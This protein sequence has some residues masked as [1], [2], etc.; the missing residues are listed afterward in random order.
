MPTK[1]FLHEIGV[2][3]DNVCP[4]CES[5]VETIQHLF[6]YCRYIWNACFFIEGLIRKYSGDKYFFL[7][8][9]NRILGHHM[10]PVE[11]LLIVK[12]LKEIWNVRCKLAFNS[13][14]SRSD[15]DIIYQY[16]INLKN[17]LVMEKNRLR[18]DVFQLHHMKNRAL[19]I[20]DEG[21]NLTFCF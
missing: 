5:E 19:C 8:D 21:N 9:G 15:I 14:H 10:K 20:V 3:P 1:S 6:I 13:Y 4:L 7:N 17:F 12:M 16:K 18:N 11:S 2:C